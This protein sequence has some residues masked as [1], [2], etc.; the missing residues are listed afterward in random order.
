[1]S[2]VPRRLLSEQEYLA[3]E[4]AAA[5]RS[6][7][8]RG[9]TFAMA[10][11]SREHNL[12]A[13]NIARSF[14]NQLAIGPCEVYQSDMKVRIDPTGLY[15]YP[16]VVVA[17]GELQFAD[18]ERDVLLNPTVLI[19]VLSE[20]TAE[21]D[22]GT[23]ATLYRLR[24]S[25]REFLLIEQDEAL[26]D[27]YIRVDAQTWQITRVS[28][29]DASI[30]FASIRCTLTLADAFAKVRFPAKPRRLLRVTGEEEP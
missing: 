8:Y 13:A 7:F 5:Y 14:G 12:I 3:R 1:M 11:A 26:A 15:T 21:Y 25:L 30:E 28:G 19:E 17:C 29:L 20:S 24:E 23:K 4:R 18:D 27:H 10:G 22:C 16:D 2:S 9:E 6:E